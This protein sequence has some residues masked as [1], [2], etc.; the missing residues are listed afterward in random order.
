MADEQGNVKD[1][2]E[3]L[4]AEGNRRMPSITA[5]GEMGLMTP[6]GPGD[7]VAIGVLKGGRFLPSMTMGILTRIPMGK[8]LLGVF[9]L[10]QREGENVPPNIITQVGG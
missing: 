10:P 2:F 8:Y 7:K 6:L 1:M 4:V 9:I 5:W 3:A